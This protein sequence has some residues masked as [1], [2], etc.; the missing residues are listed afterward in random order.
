MDKR[1]AIELKVLAGSS[2]DEAVET[3]MEYK[4]EDKNVYLVFNGHK[5]YSSD[6][7]LDDA[8][9]KVTGHTKA[10]YDKLLRE[11]QKRFEERRKVKETEAK[12]K[13]S[14]WIEEGRKYIDKDL[15]GDWEDCVYNGSNG[16]YYGMEL[17]SFLEIARLI[18]DNEVKSKQDVEAVLDTQGH[19]GASYPLIKRMLNHFSSDYAG[20]T[21]DTPSMPKT[22]DAENNKQFDR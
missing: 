11:E 8:Y 1:D 2:L 5:L 3:L 7:T 4:A 22:L 15:W 6:I 18:R 19:S 17:D 20:L 9:K 21:Q 16:A 12:N 13:I 10:E 14:Y